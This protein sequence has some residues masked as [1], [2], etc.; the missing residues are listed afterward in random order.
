MIDTEENIK[1]LYPIIRSRISSDKALTLLH[2]GALRT[3]ITTGIDALVLAIG[4]EKTGQEFFHHAPPT[5]EEVEN[6]INVVEEEV[7][8]AY[9]MTGKRSILCTTDNSIR[10]IAQLAGVLEQPE[11]LLSREAMESLFNRLAALSMGRPTA[12][13]D[14]RVDASFS[15]TILILREIMFHLGFKFINV[16]QIAEQN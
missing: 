3:I 13:D 9:K 7:I 15:A 14:L 6:A 11:M 2:I 10:E 12:K 1:R 8:R 4:T 16:I 5:P